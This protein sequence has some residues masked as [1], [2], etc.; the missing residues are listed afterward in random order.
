MKKIAILFLISLFS[1][2]EGNSQYFQGNFTNSSNTL[3]FKMK[4]SANLTTA[5]TYLEF[6]FRYVTASTPSF[7]ISNLV[8]GAQFPGINLQRRSDYVSGPYTYVR[9]VHNTST[10]ASFAYVSG[11]EYE[12]GRLNLIGSGVGNFDMA[13]DLIDP[14]NETV[15]GV[16]DGTGN[17]IDPGSNDELY[18]PGFNIM[19]NLHLLPLANVP[20]PVKFT[21]FTAIKKGENGLLNW[22]VEN[23]TAITD[24][25]MVERSLNGRDFTSIANVERKGSGSTNVYDYTDNNLKALRSDIIY[26]RI[27]QLDKDGKFAYTEIRSIRLDGK[28]FSANVFPNPVS[29]TGSVNI[30]LVNDVKINIILTDAAG[31]EIQKAMID[32]KEGLNIYKL[33]MSTLAS[34]TYQLKI[35]AG[36]ENKVLSVIKSK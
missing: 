20:V 11:T 23:E 7:T 3:I 13:S 21:G 26:Y 35:I 8:N 36:N 34:G 29:S 31:K 6:C 22:Q 30:D 17:L 19:G 28:S 27:K 12:I 15:F 2:T 14:S 32:G 5:I 1:I 10:I 24:Q 25:Y 18:G 33:N 16:I 4:P 9:Y